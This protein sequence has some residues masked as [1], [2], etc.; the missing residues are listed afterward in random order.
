MPKNDGLLDGFHFSDSEA[1]D[2]AA[3]DQQIIAYLEK[4]VDI[5]NATQALRVYQQAIAQDLFSSVVGYTFLKELQEALISEGKLSKETATPIP[6]KIQVRTVEKT[7]EK[8]V[9]V[10]VPVKEKGRFGD[11]KYK[12][13]NRSLVVII[14]ILIAVIASMFFILLSSNLPNIVNYRTKIVNEYSSW[15]TE[16][17]DKEHALDLREQELNDRET[18]LNETYGIDSDSDSSIGQEQTVPDGDV[19]QSTQTEVDAQ[20][21]QSTDSTDNSSD[22]ALLPQN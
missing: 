6:V 19:T 3:K 12:N 13:K 7:V 20:T 11:G 21:E 17:K 15:E 4:Q 1:Y 8:K 10:P 5:T 16:L 18:T 2:A 14:V 22:G 9:E